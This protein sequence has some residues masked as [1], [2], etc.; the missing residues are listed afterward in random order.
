VKTRLAVA[1]AVLAAL[2]E[3]SAAP[4]ADELAKQTQN[5]R[6]DVSSLFLRPL[7]TTTS[8]AGPCLARP[9]GGAS[10]RFRLTAT[11]LFPR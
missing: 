8:A 5:H 1:L 2:P 4:G 6:D 9:D 3:V 11:F 7:P 10:W